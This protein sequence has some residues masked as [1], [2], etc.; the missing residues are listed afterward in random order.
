MTAPRPQALLPSSYQAPAV[1]QSPGAPHGERAPGPVLTS[2]VQAD[3]VVVG[4]GLTGLATALELARRGV[5]PVVVEALTPGAGTTGRTTAKVSLLQGTKLSRL[6]ELHPPDVVDQYLAANARGKAWLAD[7][8]SGAGLRWDTRDA[9]TFALD[10]QETPSVRREHDVCRR[11]GLAAT[12]DDLPE[13]AFPHGPGLRL[14]GQAQVQ[15]LEVVG[16]LLDELDALGVTV[17][18]RSRV[19]SVRRAGA[20]A[21]TVR[22]DG[23]QVSA[24]HAVLA[25]GI[26]LGRLGGFFARLEPQ[27]SYLA[28]YTVPGDVPAGMYLSAGQDARSL[29][30]AQDPSGDG[31]QLLVGGEG[32]VVGREPETTDRLRALDRWTT[33]WFPGA[34][35]TYA[36]S[37]QD[38]RPVAQLPLVGGITPGDGQVLVATGFDKWGMTNATAAAQVLAGRV[39][40]QVPA[41]GEVLDPWS[42]HQAR[43]AA[44]AVSLNA[45]VAGELAAGWWD[46]LR[47]A[48]PERAPVEGEGLVTRSGARPT[49]RCTVDGATHTLSAVCPHLGGVVSWNEAERSWD[50][51][52]HGSRFAPDGRVIEGP[53]THGLRPT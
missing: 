23:G 15:P 10:E 40:G 16:A 41:W 50:C 46:A 7:L 48:G 22:T 44:R 25:T 19:L 36:W 39:V 38:Y 30:T 13:L 17:Y 52:L 14:A 27:R 37:A 53:A 21:V 9:V 4:A 31:L 51:G 8:C 33:R 6:A 35:R 5:R 42:S 18:E 29:R 34:R 3:V 43:G 12:L 11:L 1:W 20:R 45:G 49:A 32:H 47:P 26:P 2:N 28:S 24:R